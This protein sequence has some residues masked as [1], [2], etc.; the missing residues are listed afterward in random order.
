MPE[1]DDDEMLTPMDLKRLKPKFGLALQRKQR[2]AGEFI[3]HIR[4]GNRYF[5]RRSSVEKW[6]AEQEAKASGGGNVTA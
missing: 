6:L 4:I 2:E 1:P 5:Y 3:P